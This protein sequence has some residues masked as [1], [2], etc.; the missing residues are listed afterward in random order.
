MRISVTPDGIVL[1]DGEA[2]AV[3]LALP[4][5]VRAMHWD[6]E[7]GFA[8][9]ASGLSPRD[10]DDLKPWLDAWT[11]AANPASLRMIAPLEFLLRFTAAERTAIRAAA[12]ASPELADWIDQA[13]FAREIELDAA[14]TIAG[15]D[16]LIAAGLL[17][18][19][20]RAAVLA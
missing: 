16:A 7:V 9:T 19:E 18:A 6:G 5:G 8:E 2:R 1:V 12:A 17:T 15:L 11:A 4:S 14:M 10:L 13:R 3:A 20:R